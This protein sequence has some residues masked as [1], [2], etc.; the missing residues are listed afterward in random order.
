MSERI[1]QVQVEQQRVIGVDGLPDDQPQF[2]F[3]LRV[4][5]YDDYPAALADGLE[6]ARLLSS[7][8]LGSSET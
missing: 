5:R 7:A 2:A 6:A 4:S 3:V 1:V 8:H